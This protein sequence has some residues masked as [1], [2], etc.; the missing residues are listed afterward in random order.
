MKIH[1]VGVE[2]FHADGRTEGR[3]DVRTDRRTYGWTDM[4]KLIVPFRNF[5]N[6]PKIIEDAQTSEIPSISLPFRYV[7]RFNPYPSN[8]VNIVS[9]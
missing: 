8:A 3:A 7:P 6:E 4:T 1:P 5:A 2:L 9:S